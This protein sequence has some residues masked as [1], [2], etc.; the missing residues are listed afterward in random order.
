MENAHLW[1]QDV[2]DELVEALPDWDDTFEPEEM[3]AIAT[4]LERTPLDTLLVMSDDE[5]ERVN[6]EDVPLAERSD[7]S[8]IFLLSDLVYGPGMW[9]DSYEIQVASGEWMISDTPNLGQP[10]DPG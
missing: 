10:R 4:A 6:T 9:I 5:S 3:A 2:R 8:L 1:T 7:A